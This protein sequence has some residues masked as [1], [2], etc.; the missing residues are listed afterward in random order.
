MSSLRERRF[1]RTTSFRERM[2]FKEGLF[3]QPAKAF[4][5]YEQRQGPGSRTDFLSYA[6]VFYLYLTDYAYLCSLNILVPIY[7]TIISNESA[8]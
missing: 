1:F 3:Y 6:V 2:L 8:L 7:V 5:P 4:P